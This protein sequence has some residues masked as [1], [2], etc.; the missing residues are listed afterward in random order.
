MANANRENK[1][2][3][4]NSVVHCSIS[5]EV[6]LRHV[7]FCPLAILDVL[8]KIAVDLIVDLD[9]IVPETLPK[10]TES[11]WHRK[12]RRT[13]TLPVRSRLGLESCIII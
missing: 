10:W 5:R 8:S 12:S 13:A 1:E 3:R 6:I 2:F 7:H 9:K 4:A 11:G